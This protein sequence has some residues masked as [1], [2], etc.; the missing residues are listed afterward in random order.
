MTER[1]LVIVPTYNELTNLGQI[2]PQ[3]LAQDERLDILVVDDNSPDGTGELA[4]RL[5]TENPRIHAIHREGKQ[6][7]GTAYIAGFRLPAGSKLCRCP[8]NP[9]RRHG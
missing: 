1:A 2:V 5:A 7:L 9:R 8:A 4:D 6:G 3:I